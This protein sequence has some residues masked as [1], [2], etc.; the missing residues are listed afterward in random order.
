MKVTKFNHA[1]LSTKAICIEYLREF[2]VARDWSKVK[3]DEMRAMLRSK[4]TQDM[5]NAALTIAYRKGERFVESDFLITDFEP[6]FNRDLFDS[7]AV[8]VAFI[9]E[10]P[11]GKNYSEAFI[12]GLSLADA[13]SLLRNDATDAE[14]FEAAKII[15]ER[16]GDTFEA[17]EFEAT[18][19]DGLPEQATGVPEFERA[20]AAHAAEVE[21]VEAKPK[22]KAAP[23]A[24]PDASPDVGQVA[25]LLAKLLASGK[26][27]AVDVE[28]VT[29]IAK[30]VSA[31]S[32]D[33]LLA[34]MSAMIASAVKSIPAREIQI[35]TE[36]TSVK[37]DGL[38][39]R[40]FEKLLRAC[41]AKTHEGRLNVWLYGPPGTGK[42]TA[43]RNVAKALDLPFYCTG[44]LLT[45]YDITGFIA[46][47]GDLIRSPFRDAWEKGGVFLFD[48]IDGS[49]P[50][51]IVAF[52]SA[53]ANGVMAF[54]DGMV[55]RHPDCVIIA[56]ANTTGMGA[57]AEFNG[58]IKLDMASAD[59]FVMIDWPIDE[60]IETA[61]SH[62]KEWADVVQRV[63]ANVKRNGVKNVAITPRATIYGNSLIAAGMSIEDAK[64]MVLR[65]GMSNEQWAA[66]C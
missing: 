65:K 30:A 5:L 63:R 20:R 7:K 19:D 42:T 22:A 13:R 35:T 36:K 60:K 52:N 37:I 51:A 15:V 41:S 59:R 8:C 46:A 62:S 48:E 21:T 26:G 16:D 24:A 31:E 66:V 34:S 38:Q 29:A 50:R 54:P 39:H 32:A 4:D 12:E 40:N 3:I 23:K 45:K 49:D 44:A 43:A 33:K 28:Q 61:M 11:G 1:V 9:R 25:E 53:L 55:E 47:Q 57:T 18:D 58:R 56:A 14:L 64:E 6:R 17:S 2:G 27:A 10:I